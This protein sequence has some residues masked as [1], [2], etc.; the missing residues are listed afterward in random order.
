MRW[1]LFRLG[2]VLYQASIY[3]SVVMHQSQAAIGA[4]LWVPPL[5]WEVGYF[6]W[7]WVTDK[8]TRSGASIKTLRRL[9][10][11]LTF[12]SLP[13]A[14]IPQIHSLI[15]T[16]VLM[17]V[18]MFITSGFIICG[19]AHA[20]SRYTEHHAG[21]IAGLGAGSWSAFVA[22]SY[23]WYRTSIRPSAL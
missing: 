7:G 12:L 2:F 1:E 22:H 11:L 16:L 13:L 10:V 9:F 21:L 17:F 8:Y 6:Y 18:A 3:L 15:W 5:G 20:T 23:A 19:V 14:I 4:V